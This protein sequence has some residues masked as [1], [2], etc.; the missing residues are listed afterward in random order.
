MAVVVL[1]GLNKQTCHILNINMNICKNVCEKYKTHK[2]V[3]YSTG[4]IS[5]CKSCQKMFYKK[6]I[7]SNVCVC[8]GT[9]LRNNKRSGKKIEQNIKRI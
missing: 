7:E 9:R 6:D 3:S 1:V 5:Y 4:L 2:K 8:C